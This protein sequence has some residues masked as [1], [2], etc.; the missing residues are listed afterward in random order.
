MKKILF[1]AVM[2]GVILFTGC[3][4]SDS[5]DPKAVLSEFFDALAKG[6]IEKA[7][8]LATPESQSM[9]GLMEMGMKNNKEEMSKFDKTKMQFS[10]AVIDGDKATVPVKETTSGETVNYPMKKIDGKWKVAFDKS[11]LMTMGMEKMKEKGMNPADSI[12]KAMEE[13]KGM[14]MD[15]IQREINQAMDT[16][17]RKAQ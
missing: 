12:N 6:D 17:A 2:F 1:A 7:K 3:K 14:D 4:T 9:L 10:T 13:L 16:S 8:T 5:G 11:S 15:S